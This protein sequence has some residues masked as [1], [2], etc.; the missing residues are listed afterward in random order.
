MPGGMGI[1]SG[2][3]GSSSITNSINNSRRSSCIGDSSLNN[4]RES[5]SSA[6]E[7]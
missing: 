7:L 6:G 1:S 4:N 5:G 3:D 2:G